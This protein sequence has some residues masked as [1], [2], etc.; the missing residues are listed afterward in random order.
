MIGTNQKFV[1]VQKEIERIDAVDRAREVLNRYGGPPTKKTL[2]EALE[3]SR[4][5]RGEWNE[6]VQVPR[7]LNEKD[8]KFKT[9]WNFLVSLC[10]KAEAAEDTITHLEVSYE[11]DIKRYG[12]IGARILYRKEALRSIIPLLNWVLHHTISIVRRFE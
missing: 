7:V 10:S 11:R 3:R 2:Q 9:R 4:R 12:I 8:Q 1:S 6:S 5:R